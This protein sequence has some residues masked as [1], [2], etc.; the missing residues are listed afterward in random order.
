[1]ILGD[2][3]CSTSE[4]QSSIS[5]VSASIITLSQRESS[6]IFASHLHEVQEI[7]QIKALKNL[8]VFHISVEYDEHTNILKYDRKLKK[9]RCSSLY[10]LEVCKSLQLPPEFLLL[11]N[12]IR[13]SQLGMH[14][15]IVSTKTSR[16]SS[17]VFVDMCSICKINN[18]QE[19][20]HVQEQHTAD[21][22]GFIGSIHKNHASNL[23]PLCEGCHNNIHNKTQPVNNNLQE[24]IRKLKDEGKSNVF[25]SKE[26]NISM[27]M[28]QK[29]LKK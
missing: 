29:M 17:E 20:H 28:V 15:T 4:S 24:K 21:K 10:G 16:Y 1:M 2:E 27:Y 22:N 3:I 5:I 26:L 8:N 6:F 19:V 7:D 18:A 9:G 12:Q 14:Q 23:L 13:Q 11:A 25:I